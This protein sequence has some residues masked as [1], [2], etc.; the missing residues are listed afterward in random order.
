MNLDIGLVQ[1]PVYAGLVAAVLMV[2][3]LVLMGRVIA[4]RGQTDVLIGTGD[5]AP[6]ELR[7]RVHANFLE[8]VPTFMVGLALIEMIS[9]SSIWVAALGGVFVI[10]RIVHAVGLGRSSGVT[11]ERF[12]GTVGSMLSTLVAAVYLGYLTIQQL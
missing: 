2:I 7:M 1:M 12:I 5:S 10:A 8:N 9:G 4:S 6:L 3:Q 11:P